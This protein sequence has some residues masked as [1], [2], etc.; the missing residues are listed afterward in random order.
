MV[1]LMDIVELLLGV[2]IGDESF[3]VVVVSCCLESV[4]VGES[5][6]EDAAG[7]GDGDGPLAASI[8]REARILFGVAF[9]DCELSFTPV[10]NVV[11][12]ALSVERL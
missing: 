6:C 7:A 12:L 4:G 10:G 11:E 5:D 1:G 2:P 8:L 9:A 3:N